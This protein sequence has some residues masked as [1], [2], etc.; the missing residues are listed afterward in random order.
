MTLLIVY[1]FAAVIVVMVIAVQKGEVFKYKFITSNHGI[2]IKT[3]LLA[4]KFEVCVR[5][6]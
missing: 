5:F 1:M 6:C 4:N 2:T 3:S